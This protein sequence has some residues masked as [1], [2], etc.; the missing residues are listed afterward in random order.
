MFR[1]RVQW[2]PIEIEYLQKH[3][4]SIPIDQLTI[5]LAKSRNAI[6]NKLAE[7]AG[8]PVKKGKKSG[9]KSKIGKR[10]DLGIFQRSGWEADFLRYCIYKGLKADY[11]PTT[12][13]FITFGITHGT[14]S[15]TPDFKLYTK[16][17]YL[18]I[19]VKGFLKTSDKTRIRRFKKYFPQEFDKLQ[20]I[21]GSPNTA[22]DKFFKSM[23]V[24]I[25]AYFNDWKKK[26]KDIVPNWES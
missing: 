2:S 23:N 6:K 19:E 12:F 11:E 13:S 15:F 17:D 20:V 26:Y 18:W 4:S 1:N 10:K 3:H 7:L 21:V 25:Y 14:V 8:K 22:A 16:N 24:P 9:A 5:A